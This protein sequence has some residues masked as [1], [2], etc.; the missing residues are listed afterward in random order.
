MLPDTTHPLAAALVLGLSI[1]A[2]V[3][4]GTEYAWLFIGLFVGGLLGVVLWYF[5]REP[6]A[7]R[8]ARSKA[9]RLAAIVENAQDA[10]IAKDLQGVITNWNPAAEDLFGYSHA[11]VVGKSIELIIPSERRQ[12]HQEALE[13]VK[14]GEAVERA[15]TVRL[16]K[17]GKRIDVSSAVSPIKNE[18]GEVV[19]AAKVA[20]EI[21]SRKR[22]ENALRF[23]TEAGTVLSELVDYQTAAQNVARLATAFY[24]DWCVVRLMGPSGQI[25][26]VSCTHADAAKQPLLETLVRRTSQ[27]PDDLSPS[28]HVM[29]TGKPQLVTAAVTLF[30]A[31]ASWDEELAA[32]LRG[33]EP[34]SIILTPISI[35][36]RV[37]GVL[38]LATCKPHRQYGLTDV[39]VAAEFARARR[40]PSTMLSSISTCANPNGRK[41]TFWRCSPMS[42]AIRWRP[43]NMPTRSPSSTKPSPATSRK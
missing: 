28:V 33:L 4:L 42:C 1:T 14:R 19:G 20:Y 35:R 22:R 39:S 9:R 38:E 36:D 34:A 11:E 17:N 15:D 23:L 30:A 43:S 6:E 25:E 13:R 29:R 8:V 24:A 7:D 16:H 2:L 41:T 3:P 12:E 18:A 40:R 37:I 5:T 10:I 31:T 26:A 21:T 27:T 32:L